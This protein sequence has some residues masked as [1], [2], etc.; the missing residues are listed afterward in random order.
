MIHL[1]DVNKTYQVGCSKSINF[2][3][4]FLHRNTS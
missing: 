4:R 3:T 2:L 1:K